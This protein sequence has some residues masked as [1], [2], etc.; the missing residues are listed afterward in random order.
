MTARRPRPRVTLPTAKRREPY[1]KRHRASGPAG[2]FRPPRS[3]ERRDRK[4]FRPRHRPA[5][6]QRRR[7]DHP[8][9]HPARLPPADLGQRPAL[10][11]RPDHRRRQKRPLAGRLHARTR[12][13]HRR[14]VGGAFPAADGRAVRAAAQGGARKG[15]RSPLLRR[16][17]RGPLPPARDLLAGH[18]AARQ[19]GPGPGARAQADL[20]RRADQR[21]RPAGPRTDDPA[22]AG[23]R[24]KPATCTCCSPRTC[25]ATSRNAA[26]RC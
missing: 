15:A 14:H 3:A 2:P 26:K 18:E 21:A 20:P 10:R 6:P 8:D 7:Q 22:G 13:F 23:H 16:P 25:C 9:P 19:A 5:R 1:D 24:A 12:R 17:R 11:P 4:A